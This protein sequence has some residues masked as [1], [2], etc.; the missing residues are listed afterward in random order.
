MRKTFL[1][2]SLI[3]GYLGYVCAWTNTRWDLNRSSFTD[4]TAT[5]TRI[6]DSNHGDFLTH[7]T[8]GKCGGPQ[9]SRLTIYDSSGTTDLD[10]RIWEVDT[11]S[12]ATSCNAIADYPIFVQISSGITYTLTG[13]SSPVIMIYW[14][15][16][17]QGD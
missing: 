1:A 11:S 17:V 9:P 13:S 14:K 8:I 4:A 6:E 7:V 2:V 10:E 3:L 16:E 15:D 12:N 5:A